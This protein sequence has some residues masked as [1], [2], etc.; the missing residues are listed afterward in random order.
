MLP[1]ISETPDVPDERGARLQRRDDPTVRILVSVQEVGRFE[2]AIEASG[3]MN[4][5]SA[6]MEICDHYVKTKRQLDPLA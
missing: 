6:L 1:S 2:R 4:R 3:L 5:A